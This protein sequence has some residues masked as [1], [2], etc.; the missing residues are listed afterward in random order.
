MPKEQIVI[1]VVVAVLCTVGLFNDRWFLAETR[2]GQ[3]LVGWL[4]EQNA[5]WVLRGLFTLGVAFGALLA[6]DVLGPIRW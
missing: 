4:G 1:G 3:R 2:K 6:T 5:L